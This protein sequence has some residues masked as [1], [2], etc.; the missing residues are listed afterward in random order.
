M[1]TGRPG[2]GIL[3]G[4][5]SGE[6]R[7]SGVERDPDGNRGRLRSQG[8][9]KP[10]VYGDPRTEGNP[11]TEEDPGTDA[12]LGT[13]GYAGTDADPGFGREGGR[14]PN[15][16]GALQGARIAR[17]KEAEGQRARS[18]PESQSAP[19][20]FTGFG[21]E[22]RGGDILHPCV[23]PPPPRPAA[24]A[25]PAESSLRPSSQWRPSSLAAF[26]GP[27]RATSPP[28]AEARLP[29]AA[30][31]P[32]PRPPGFPAPTHGSWTLQADGE[33]RRGV[34]GSAPAGTMRRTEG[35]AGRGGRSGPRHFRA[36]L[37]SRVSPP[38]ARRRP[39]RGSRGWSCGRRCAPRRF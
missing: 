22:R 7:G 34:C 11:E 25:V 9:W 31:P 37:G 8:V 27:A 28:R 21:T 30:P 4:W 15:A 16:A 26:P 39:P 12:D 20:P 19:S 5:R 29:Q 18:A 36:A 35:A 10:G 32:Q 2:N 3:G 13:E 23:P 24:Q 14:A 17:L 1:W 38:A 6:G 33:R